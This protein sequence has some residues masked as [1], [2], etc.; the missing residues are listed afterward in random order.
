MVGEYSISVQPADYSIPKSPAN[1]S[2]SLA[3]SDHN[4]S[5]RTSDMSASKTHQYK[6]RTTRFQKVFSLS[7]LLSGS[8]SSRENSERSSSRNSL[9][10]DFSRSI[11][12]NGPGAFWNKATNATDN[13]DDQSS[14]TISEVNAKSQQVIEGDIE[15]GRDEHSDVK[16][17]K[18]QNEA[19]GILSPGMTINPA[20][21]NIKKRFSLEPLSSSITTADYDISP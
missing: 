9:N 21:T 10:S 8:L 5:I 3:P 2:V 18:A 17:I 12:E 14:S 19:A 11:D 13:A 15:E 4:D 1:Q 6:P 7:R 20:S 16:R